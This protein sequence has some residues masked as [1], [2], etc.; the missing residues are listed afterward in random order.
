[1]ATAIQIIRRAL[2]LARVLDVGEAV[3]ASDAQD[4]LAALNT[5][6]AEWY[7]DGV[8][9]PQFVAETLDGDLTMSTADVEA[10]AHQLAVRLAPEYGAELS[11]LTLA[12][13][14]STMNL[15]RLR[16]HQ[17]GSAIVELPPAAQR[18]WPY[19]IQQGG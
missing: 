18:G 10:V 1:M 3:E 14:A 16:Y 17:P 5:M 4:A 6:L 12:N 11:P 15:L 7:E 19:D 8:G 9:L 13:A 2:R